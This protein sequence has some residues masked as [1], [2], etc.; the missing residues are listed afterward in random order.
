MLKTVTTKKTIGRRARSAQKRLCKIHGRPIR[1]SYWRAGHRNTGCTE[2]YRT[3]T[4]PPPKKRLCKEHRLPILRSRWWSGY[5]NRGC[6]LCF[7]VPPPAKR[8]CVRHG[9]PISP[10]AWRNGRHS[11]GCSRCHNSRPGYL[12]AKARYNKRRRQSASKAR[13]ARKKTR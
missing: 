10:S 11:T 7:K 9:R 5:R 2:C 4:V 8:L 3:K 6:L 13:K 12:E 1:P